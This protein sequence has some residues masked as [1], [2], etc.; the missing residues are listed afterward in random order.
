MP[1]KKSGRRRTRKMQ[2]HGRRMRGGERLSSAQK[3]DLRAKI[4]SILLTIRGVTESG[5]DRA[6][7]TRVMREALARVTIPN[8]ATVI[9]AGVMASRAGVP[10]FGYLSS[11]TCGAATMAFNVLGQLGAGLNVLD[12]FG[13]QAGLITLTSAFAIGAATAA[14]APSVIAG[15]QGRN[16][17]ASDA[18]ITA[19]KDQEGLVSVG[20]SAGQLLNIT[21]D[22]V[23]DIILRAVVLI[24]EL[25]DATYDS[26]SKIISASIGVFQTNVNDL[27]RQ[28]AI[29]IDPDSQPSQD[30]QNSVDEVVKFLYGEVQDVEN[31]QDECDVEGGGGEGMDSDQIAESQKRLD[32]I[33]DAV[34]RISS[35]RAPS[36]NVPMAAGGG[37]GGGVVPEDLSHDEDSASQ[38][39]V[40]IPLLSKKEEKGEDMDNLREYKS[41]DEDDA[42]Y[43][44]EKRKYDSPDSQ[45]SAEQPKKD[46]KMEEPVEYEPVAEN[47]PNDGKDNDDDDDSDIS[48]LKGGRR[49]KRSVK[50]RSKTIRRKMS[51]KRRRTVRRGKSTRR[52]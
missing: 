41:D 20:R 38:L 43:L 19:A 51:N 24:A 40:E 35:R 9:G 2:K 46:M 26:L 25:P 30:S 7:L 5:I 6:D 23:V 14:V 36:L 17:G 13:P 49:R 16:A 18:L 34:S 15:F 33:L 45:D 12:R 44:R 48:D 10:I 52:K 21:L 22:D 47:S 27:L 32:A 29:D 31:T 8:T 11:L 39:S 37:G 50:R 28:E 3:R 4:R 42:G 1:V